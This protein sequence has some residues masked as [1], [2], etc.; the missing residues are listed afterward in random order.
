[1][2]M[3]RSTEQANF[4]AIVAKHLSI[5]DAP[6]LL[7][8]ATGI[9]KTRAYLKAVMDAA[10]S[11][12]RITIVVPT[13]QLIDQLI[14][15]SD[16]IQTQLEG[17]RVIGF[18]P[19]R[20]FENKSQYSEH[21]NQALNAEIMVCTSASIIIDQRLGGQYNGST[22][23]EYIL[24]DEADQLPDM[25]ALQSDQDISIKIFKENNIKV[26]DPRQAVLELLKK[27]GLEPE[28]RATGIMILEA[29]DEPAW[30]Y[31]VG[32]N[33]DGGVSLYHKM[34]GRLLKKIAN[35]PNVAFI[36]ATLS[37]G[38]NFNDFKMALGIKNESSLSR[39]I[40]P[41]IHGELSFDVSDIDVKSP[42]WLELNKTTIE[43]ASKPVLVVTPS[44]DLASLL[45]QMI[46]GSI[47]RNKD[48]TSIQAAARLGSSQVLIA[49][50]AWAG[51]DT[52]I[53]WASVIIPR[54]PY[55][56]PMVLDDNI[57]SSF[58][59][60][61]NKAIRRMKQVIGRGLRSADAK[62]SI[63][64]L[65]ARYK[66][67]ESFVPKRFKSLWQSKTYLEGKRSEISLSKAE[68]DPSIRKHALKFYGER[69]MSCCLN[70]RSSNVL[71]VHHLFP[72]SEG[73]R[74]TNIKDLAILCANCHRLIHTTNPP[75][76]L[77]LLKIF[78]KE[79]N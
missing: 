28:I 20:F 33:S 54:I 11:G 22:E 58:L 16:L 21:K 17:V 25:A 13:H 29:L 64:I 43:N 51:L 41:E 49:T 63:Y 57:E 6:L 50:G 1:M 72:I 32:I 14:S 15:S 52:P 59:N 67:I 2:M 3:F 61:R 79:N 73:E 30:F 74:K 35:K 55:D 38:D 5:Q 4:S 37:I 18:R 26:E 71:D 24:F 76:S 53:K 19:L 70:P 34:P 60:S 9:G 48:E 68:R 39:I 10:K 65:D 40:E 77:D 31:K 78:I 62:C 56:P 66:N 47:V 69:C 46:Q 23:R 12:K 27:K 42:E 75:M 44:H 7:E 8:G 45:G 36:S